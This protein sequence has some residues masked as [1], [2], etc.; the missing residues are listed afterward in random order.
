MK[1]TPRMWDVLAE[2]V[3]A[4]D[5]KGY[6]YDVAK[7]TGMTATTVSELVTRFVDAQWFTERTVNEPGSKYPARRYFQLV[8]GRVSLAEKLLASRSIE[9]AGREHWPALA[10]RANGAW[11]VFCTACSDAAREHVYPCRAGRW[12]EPIPPAV[13]VGEPSPVVPGPVMPRPVMPRPT[14]QVCAVLEVLIDD[15]IRE[16]YGRKISQTTGLMPSTVTAIMK[17]LAAAG[18]VTDRLAEADTDA[19]GPSRRRYYQLVPEHVEPLRK[20]LADQELRLVPVTSRR[21]K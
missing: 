14:P 3:S 4:P 20:L 19:T 7:A 6:V 16:H 18:W 11:G 2:I 12:T 9:P 21:R 15:R 17:R 1:F 5:H 10:S 13:V 8:P